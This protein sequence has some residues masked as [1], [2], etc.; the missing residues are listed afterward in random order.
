MPGCTGSSHISGLEQLAHVDTVY[1]EVDTIS[2]LTECIYPYQMEKVGEHLIIRDLGN[3][4]QLLFSLDLEGNQEKHFANKGRAENE[5]GEIGRFH[6]IDSSRISIAKQ[7]GLLI[8]HIDSICNQSKQSHTF[9]RFPE[10]PYIVSNANL[11]EHGFLMSLTSDS[12]RF[13]LAG[14]DGSLHTYNEYPN[15]FVDEEADVRAVVNY[16]ANYS[17][18][19]RS[20]RFCTGTYIGGMLQTFR[21]ENKKIKLIGTNILFKSHYHKLQNGAVSWDEKSKIGFDAI[22]AKEHQIYTLLNQNEGIVL[23][24]G[25]PNPFATSIT[26]FDWDARPAK[27]IEVGLPMMCLCVSDSENEAYAIHYADSD[28]HLIRIRW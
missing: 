23:K 27:I 1:A 17:I 19:P 24:N 16:A 8:F 26:V 4:S 14:K 28:L 13:C 5:V 20:E 10:V 25:G 9:L 18:D 6:R 2:A 12:A 11:T 21:I 7:N 3:P 22:A 15:G